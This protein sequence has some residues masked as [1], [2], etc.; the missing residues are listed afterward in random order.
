MKKKITIILVTL[1]MCLGISGS[2]AA[3]ARMIRLVKGHKVILKGTVREGDEK[4]YIFMAK[5]GQ[6]LTVRVIGR[7]AVFFAVRRSRLYG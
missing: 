4:N 1:L 6:R 7:D 3:Q 2:A 5:E